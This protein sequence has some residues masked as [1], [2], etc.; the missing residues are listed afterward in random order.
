MSAQV[1]VRDFSNPFMVPKG[2]IIDFAFLLLF[3]R[4][5]RSS[6]ILRGDDWTKGKGRVLLMNIFDVREIEVEGFV[7]AHEVAEV[8][9]AFRMVFVELLDEVFGDLSFSVFISRTFSAIYIL[10]RK[11]KRNMGKHGDDTPSD[12]QGQLH[13]YRMCFFKWCDHIVCS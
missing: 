5:L 11:R 7:V 8:H 4:H 9:D 6:H 13:C 10:K 3:G 2:E 1:E 12:Q